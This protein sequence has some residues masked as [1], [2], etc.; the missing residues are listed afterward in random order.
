MRRLAL[1]LLVASVL[2]CG[3]QPAPDVKPIKDTIENRVAE[4]NR[5]LS[6]MPPR[7]MMIDLT[8][9]M[10]LQMPVEARQLYIDLMTKHLDLDKF[11]LII[12]NTMVE[13]YTAEELQAFANFCSSPI[14]RSALKVS[15]QVFADAWPRMQPLMLDAFQKAT[16]EMENK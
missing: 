15:G 1:A 9:K 16:A 8:R 10:S 5:Y 7:D 3:T 11:T 2:A 13:N 6:V 14:G 12:H 4:A